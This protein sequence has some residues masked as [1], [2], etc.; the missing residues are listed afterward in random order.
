MIRRG[1]ASA[2]AALALAACAPPATPAAPA[3]LATT[4]AAGI[5]AADLRHRVEV[6][7][8]DSMEGREVGTRG[9]ERT[10]R[11][12]A[13]DLARIGLRPAGDGG[14]WLHRVPMTRTRTALA[15]AHA[16]PAGETALTLR[17]LV[18]LNGIG[19]FPESAR[20][21]VE[22][23]LV[24]AGWQVDA[25]VAPGD[26]LPRE[27][28]SGAVVVM[29]AGEAPGTPPGARPRLD[30]ARLLDA[31]GAAAVVLVGE[32]EYAEFFEYASSVARSGHFQRA[33][34][35]AGDRPLA[36]MASPDAVE[37]MLGRPLDGRPS[38]GHGTVRLEV[39]RLREAVDASNVVG[40]LPGRDPRLA[41]EYVALGAHHDHDGIGE[42]VD[43]DSIFNGADDNA[44]G[45]AALLEIAERLAALPEAARPARSLLFVWHTAEEKGLLGSEAFT[46]RPT[47]PREAIVAHL[48]ADMIARNAT[49][50]IHVIGS[51]RLS[52]QMGALV[53]AVNARQPRPFGLDYAWDAPEHPE[54]IYCR[55]DHY[56]YA[57]FGIPVAFF[58]AGL[59]E[60][61]H[62]VRDT[63]EKLDYDK[64][65]R[66]TRLVHDVAV[67]IADRPARLRVDRPLPPLGAP[68][69]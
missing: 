26:E 64:L 8:H 61:Y 44:S 22:G 15:G 59:H 34:P 33:A 20:T 40:L 51:R 21:R 25:G 37:R 54:G 35:P 58:F 43:G 53:E 31:G 32:G 62:T 63:A 6:L 27:R 36:L 56:N 7:A 60:D 49:D 67:E 57:R 55:S 5:T 3:P 28:L 41:A 18:P 30:L 50:S 46:E 23:P 66:V 13:A 69:R 24:Y 65:L 68:C 11:Y 10:T 38:A 29:R 14:G 42:P 47:V 1:V 12:L 16:G 4:T 48:N 39:T 2:L 45:T 19:G 9:M 17:E 52:T